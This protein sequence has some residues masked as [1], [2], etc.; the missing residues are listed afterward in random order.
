MLW[1]EGW[2]ERGQLHVWS[3]D[4]RSAACSHALLRP[5]CHYAASKRVLEPVLVRVA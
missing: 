5:A 1:Y 3:L 4:S 2:N